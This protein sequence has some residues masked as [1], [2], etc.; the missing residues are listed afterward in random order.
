MMPFLGSFFKILFLD[1]C[2][3]KI[4]ASFHR[5]RQQIERT[6]EWMMHLDPDDPYFKQ[7]SFPFL[8]TGY[9]LPKELS[10][11]SREK[12]SEPMEK[13]KSASVPTR[14]AKNKIRLFRRPGSLQPELLQYTHGYNMNVS[15]TAKY[16]LARY[17]WNYLVLL[18][19][20]KEVEKYK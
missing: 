6:N 9:D 16:E 3:C 12:E 7:G 5:F 14:G 10:K 8:R 18:S 13:K 4:D 11:I 17:S 2:L 19:S 20:E 15:G 1:I